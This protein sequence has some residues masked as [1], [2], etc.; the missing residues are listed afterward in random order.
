MKFELIFL[1]ILL[2]F[3]KSKNSHAFL[4]FDMEMVAYAGSAQSD[5]R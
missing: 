2:K 3:L 1:K 4:K 5:P